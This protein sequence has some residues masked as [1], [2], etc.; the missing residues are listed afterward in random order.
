MR[1]EIFE[2]EE[3]IPRLKAPHAI[4]MMRPWID[5]GAVGTLV[6][7]RLENQ[8]KAKKLARLSRPGDF[9]DFTRYRPEI[10]SK[11]G[12][13]EITIP[14]TEISWA[15][16]NGKNDFIFIHLLEPHISGEVFTESV[17][18]VLKRFKIQ[19]YCLLGSFFDAVPHTR[20]VMISGQATERKTQETL[21]K[22]GLRPSNYEGPV[23]ICHLI[24][25]E[26]EK[27]GVE[28]MMLMASLPQY[29]EL[30]E[31]YTGTL[32]VLQVL[33]S[34]YNLT[35][36]EFDLNRSDDQLK[37]IDSVVQQ[38]HK[39]KALVTQLEHQYDAD[40]ATRKSKEHAT[41]SPEVDSFL[42]EMEKR[43]GEN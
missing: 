40:L 16:G 26:A 24:S 5:A 18:Q 20:P 4:A 43:I 27:A 22:L 33:R 34:L 12:K 30:E 11:G 29:I 17:W 15:R 23:T 35:V 37:S 38:D 32:A 7:T 8:F 10:R 25:D 21:Q 36:D 41:L 2:V 1:I 31:D 3:P 13:R 19:R 9:Y 6:I 14:N 39:L 28:T 42:K